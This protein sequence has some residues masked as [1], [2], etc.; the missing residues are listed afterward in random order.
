MTTKFDPVYSYD[1]LTGIYNGVI[2]PMENPRRP[3]YALGI[4]FT[5]PIAPPPK[6]SGFEI[7]ISGD[8]KN[9][10]YVED[11]RGTIVYNEQGTEIVITDIGPIPNEYTTAAP[12][13]K[14]LNKEEKK[15][16]ELINKLEEL[17]KKIPRIIEDMIDKNVYEPNEYQRNI[18]EEKK[19]Y[20]EELQQLM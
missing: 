11:H 12:Q 8:K 14:G 16:F 13:I 15:K 10:E 6:K 20:R 9:W 19:K 1:V 18:I 4:A 2:T 7:V 17:D 5:T 3:G